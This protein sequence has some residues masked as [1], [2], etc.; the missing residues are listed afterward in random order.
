M[1]T[2]LYADDKEDT[3]FRPSSTALLVLDSNDRA[4]Y[5]P[6]PTWTSYTS[7]QAGE[8]A[9]YNSVV[10]VAI[11]NIQGGA[12]PA[13]NTA[14]WA[15]VSDTQDYNFTIGGEASGTAGGEGQGGIGADNTNGQNYNNFRLQKSQPLLQGG[16]QRLTVSEVTF[17]Y[18][19]P[20]ITN[21]TNY[22]WVGALD[23]NQTP[24]VYVYRKIAIPNGYYTGAALATAVETALNAAFPAGFDFAVG[25]DTTTLGF[26]I[27]TLLTRPAPLEAVSEP[28]QLFPYDPA[29]SPSANLGTTLLDVMG[30]NPKTNWVYCTS[31]SN[32]GLTSVGASLLYTKY[33]DIVSS[34]LTYYQNVSD[35]NSRR[36]GGSNVI[37]RMYI[38]NNA[39]L[40]ASFTPSPYIINRQFTNAKSIKWDKNTAIDWCDISLLD[41]S[42]RPLWYNPQTAMSGD[43][44]I[45]LLASED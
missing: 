39:A 22:M 3:T 44:Q 43:F 13:T 37:C 35:Q 6:V 38:T 23:S 36:S 27:S 7:Y 10:Y 15:V 20:N 9:L 45:T 18:N 34:K 41:D 25:Y 17:N 11:R 42:G 8:K 30:F 2:S 24:E 40:P 1:Q 14:A 12:N 19:I 29:Q 4:Y 26:S 32:Q 21:Y 33:I 16:F 31:G 5:L 28:I